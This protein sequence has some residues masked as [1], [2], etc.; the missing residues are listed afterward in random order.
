MPTEQMT[1][2]SAW[3]AVSGAGFTDDLLEWPPDVFALTNVLLGRSEAF[4]FALSPPAG[5]RW[6]PA[7]AADWSDAVVEAGRDWSAWVEDP[8]GSAP[9]VVADE[10]SVARG[11]ADLPLE[12]LAEGRDWRVCE[13]LLTLHAIADEACAG[14]GSAS[15]C[16]DRRGAAYRGRARE[17]LATT[18]SLARF[19]PRLLRVLPK[20][21]T[22]PTGRPS[23]AGA[24]ATLPRVLDVD[25]LTVLTGWA[26][27]VA[28]ALE[29]VPERIPTLLADARPGAAWRSAL[30]LPEPS[31]QL[32][33]AIAS[34]SAVVEG[35]TFDT[36]LAASRETRAGEQPLDELV[37]SV[38]R[39]TLEQLRSRQ[40]A[41]RGR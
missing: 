4:R 22:P 36:V 41:T 19:P 35:A 29:H 1:L 30:G 12:A 16:A 38:L 23:F 31:L 20:I 26:E 21:R 6:P 32:D 11:H 9:G 17:L 37:R 7:G 13:A 8:E 15:A 10:W 33:Q 24:G 2:A 28:Q 27:A 39:A 18:G 5:V 34:L 14:L 3:Q 25:D 40:A